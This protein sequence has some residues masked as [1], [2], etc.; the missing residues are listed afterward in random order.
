[1]QRYVSLFPSTLA[2][3]V[4]ACGGDSG[5]PPTT[6]T[7]P[8]IAS[9]PATS[10]PVSTPAVSTDYTAFAG[11]TPVAIIGYNDDAMEPFISK[12]GRYLLFN[13][14][15]ADPTKTDLFYATS[16]DDHT[17]R[18][19]GPISGANSP[20][21][22]GV[23]SMDTTGNLYFIS[24]RSY[25]KS[26]S[27]IY[28]AGFSA[29][30]TNQPQLVSGVS[31]L[32][33]GMLNFDAEISGDGNTLWFDDGRFSGGPVPDSATIAIAERQNT[34]F[35]RRADGAAI[36]ANVNTDGLN[37]APSISNDGLE[38]FFTRIADRARP[39][40]QIYRASRTN[41]SAAF[42]AP[43][44][45]SAIVGFVEGPSLSADGRTLYYHKLVDGKFGIYLV[46]R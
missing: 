14:S 46:R 44:R 3:L 23:A 17:F 13:N 28:V 20:A 11:E 12:D 8:P 26:L 40:P 7:I 10:P 1:M 24:T 29:G 36:L 25:E 16:I 15:N 41:P 35:M 38:L 31:L 4:T 33:P 45:V 32:Q 42:A 6:V 22:D 18:S 43:Q 30:Q 9:T 19:G 21:L 39:A 37:F 2:L 34:S 27:T 5:M